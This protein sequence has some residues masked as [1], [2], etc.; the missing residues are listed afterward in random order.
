MTK[1]LA[2]FGATG[3]Q[4][5]SVVSHVLNDPELS[6]Q[7]KIRAITRDVNS[8][9]AKHLRKKVDVVAADMADRSSLEAALAGVHTVFIMT[10]PDS[11]LK[12][13]EVEYNTAKRIADVAIEQGVQYNI[14]STLSGVT[15]MSGGNLQVHQGYAVRRQGH[16]REVHPRLAR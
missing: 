13:V 5:G 10:N 16:G 8:D 12:A 7:Y 11:G 4:G 9:K 15:E 3:Q 14:F 6:Q 1:T 2:V